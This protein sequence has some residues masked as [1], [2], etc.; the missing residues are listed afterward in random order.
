MYHNSNRKENSN[1]VTKKQKKNLEQ[2]SSFDKVIS[3][4]VSGPRKFDENSEK[5]PLHSTP[6]QSKKPNSAPL[7][8]TFLDSSAEF[9]N[10]YVVE[11]ADE[12]RLRRG[13]L[14]RKRNK[15]V[16]QSAWEITSCSEKIK[17]DQCNLTLVEKEFLGQQNELSRILTGE[18]FDFL[19]QVIEQNQTIENSST[20]YSEEETN[21]GSLTKSH[22]AVSALFETTSSDEIDSNCSGTF[23]QPIFVSK[24]KCEI[25]EP[26]IQLSNSHSSTQLSESA[27]DYYAKLVNRSQL[28]D[29]T[30]TVNSSIYDKTTQSYQNA[31][32]PS[33]SERINISTKIKY[34]I[35][36]T[37][38]ILV[39]KH[40]V[41]LHFQGKISVTVLSGAVEIL[42]YILK[43]NPDLETDFYCPR[44]NCFLCFESILSNRNTR[45]VSLLKKYSMTEGQIHGF[46][47]TLNENDC[48]LAI[49]HLKNKM[50]YYLDRHVPQQL[51]PNMQQ[52]DERPLR[53]LEKQLRCLFELETAPLKLYKKHQTWPNIVSTIIQTNCSRT[54]LCGGRSVG[55][56]TLVRYLVNSLLNE[57]EKVV[58]IDLDCG[59]SE[60]T[61][62][63]CISVTTVDTPI[64]G[65]NYTH[66]KAPDVAYFVGDVNVMNCLYRYVKCVEL[67]IKYFEENVNKN[68]PLIINH[69]GFCRSIG[70]DI[71]VHTIKLIRPT[72]V[73]Q[74]QS[75]SKGRNYLN[76]LTPEFVAN[77]KPIFSLETEFCKMNYSLTLLNSVAEQKVPGELESEPR[78]LR[79]MSILSYFSQILKENE[80]ITAAIPYW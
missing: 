40:P 14:K 73:I 80:E 7:P 55:K 25:I 60:F 69:M 72:D 4:N 41:K 5:K 15:S 62:G 27:V 37:H 48:I 39:L 26:K 54:L 6:H 65:P 58:V 36:K 11:I 51:Y 28:K 21:E 29:L 79:E 12:F 50:S 17:P 22:S 34:Y 2:F 9:A 3:K 49:R 8:L 59:Q 53:S 63:G 76:E 78:L 46:C 18:N 33:K 67:L 43:T 77:Y 10:S 30:D 56:S 1:K 61:I 24:N 38:C 52:F 68:V 32:S 42:G 44:G 47:S 13:G 23:L 19:S 16:T 66:L 64:F 75:K 71:I 57:V 20:A 35:G 70:L 74:M 45:I 31:T